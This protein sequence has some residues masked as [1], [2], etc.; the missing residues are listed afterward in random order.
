MAEFSYYMV[1]NQVYGI[2]PC[3]DGKFFNSVTDYENAYRDEENEI[4]DELARLHYNDEPIDYPEDWR[5]A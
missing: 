5:I 4:F 2:M 1:G 3:G